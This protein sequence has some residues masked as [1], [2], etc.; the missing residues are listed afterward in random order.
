M[1]TKEDMDCAAAIVGKRRLLTYIP[2][3]ALL[4]TAI[5]VFV[6]GRIN[7]NDSA[8]I[9]TAVLTG[10]AGG[11]YLFFHGVYLKPAL[12]YQLHVDYMLFGK[13]RET[14][15]ILKSFS[16]EVDERSGIECHKLL[17]NVGQKDDP[18]DDRQLYFDAAKSWPGFPIGTVL[19]MKSNDNLIAD[20]QEA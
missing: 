5:A 16:T 9:V 4:L 13:L 11:Y 6:I 20:I 2:S 3:A 14:T 19:T 8:W 1:Y 15:G 12:L 10:L 18:E 17:V 7:R